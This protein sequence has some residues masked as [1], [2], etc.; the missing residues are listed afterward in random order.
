MRDIETPDQVLQ[1]VKEFYRKVVEDEVIGHFFTVAVNLDFEKHIPKIA[2]FWSGILFGNS[3]YA[4][5]VMQS[6]INLNHIMKIEK[7]HFDRW[8]QLWEET[9]AFNYSGPKATEAVDR[10]KSIASIMQFQL[11]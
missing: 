2:E 8:L 11:S 5:N 10:A 3:Q 9:V 6:H 4:G 7:H 1:L